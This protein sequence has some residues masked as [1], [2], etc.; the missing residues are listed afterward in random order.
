MAEP[1]T[2]QILLVEDNPTDARLIEEYVSE[3]SWP[4]LDEKPTIDHVDRLADAVEARDD[5]TDVVLLDLG[6][7]DS[8]GFKTLDGM[9]AAAGDEP[10]VVLTGLDDERVGVEAVERGAQDYLVKDDLTPKLLQRT[11]RYAI[12]RERQQRRLEQRNE[13]LALLNR[14]VRHDIKNDVSIIMGWGDALDE[15]IDPA[16]EEYLERMIN[17]SDHITGIAET[18]GDFLEI[19]EGDKEAEL[20]A[21]DLGR[22]LET[23][24]EKAQSAHESATVSITGDLPH[25]LSVAAT[26]LLSSVFRNLLNNAVRHNDKTEPEVSI[27]VKVHS[28]TV[29]VRV[30]DNGPGIPESQ[31]DEIFGRG[32]KGLQSPGSGIGL[33]LVDTLVD[34]YDG[35]IHI[36]DN[37]PEGSVFAVTLHRS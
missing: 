15:Y 20:Q 8:D 16:G 10:V 4:E 25:G 19:L 27:D 9:L 31:R 28:E 11:I 2:E 7:P 26:E 13:E 18:V 17:A 6:L 21:I 37:E 32:E 12:E 14:I 30:A 23:E 3:Q 1:T 36:T 22:L 29:T 33:Y 5:E 35:E 34:M 24:V